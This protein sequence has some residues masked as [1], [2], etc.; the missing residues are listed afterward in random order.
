MSENLEI[1][2]LKFDFEFLTS[3]G[4]GVNADASASLNEIAGLTRARYSGDA[5]GVPP[6]GRRIYG[7]V[8]TH[9]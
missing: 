3:P 8:H 1:L 7:G 6:C 9:A 4:G 2:I 5:P